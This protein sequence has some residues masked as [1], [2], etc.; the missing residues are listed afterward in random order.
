[1]T[2]TVSLPYDTVETVTVAVHGSVVV[3]L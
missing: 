3:P 1:V 2:T